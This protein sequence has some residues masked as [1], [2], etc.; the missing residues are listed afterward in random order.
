MQA[1]ST[2]PEALDRFLVIK[3]V[4]LILVLPAL[5]VVFFVLDLGGLT[6]LMLAVLVTMALVLGP[7]AILN[8]RVEDRAH[9]IRIALPE[10]LDLLVIS[11]EA[12]LGFEQALDR[13][14]EAVPGPLT[15]GVR[16]H[17]R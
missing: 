5:Y 1:G 12:G 11:V 17:A 16:S 14:V 10:I 9:Q 4:C 15:D 7:D 2:E 3:G 8:R 6:Q 13:V